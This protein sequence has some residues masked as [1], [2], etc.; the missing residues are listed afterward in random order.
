MENAIIR[1]LRKAEDLE[2]LIA[3]LTSK[4]YT[5]ATVR[6]ALTHLLVGASWDEVDRLAAESPSAVRLLAARDAGR[7]FMRERDDETI[8]IVTNRNKE[9]D[10]LSPSDRELLDLDERAADLYNLLRGRDIRTSSDRVMR[11]YIE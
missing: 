1:E 9:D 4:R 11:P 3:A 6:R 2:Q 10:Q 8:R 5:Q 7:R